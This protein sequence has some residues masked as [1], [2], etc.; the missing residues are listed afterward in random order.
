MPWSTMPVQVHDR[1]VLLRWATTPEGG[2]Y[3]KL[4]AKS[5]WDE[6]H[7]NPSVDRDKNSK[8]GAERLTH[9]YV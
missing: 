2:C 4:E 3:S 5:R 6:F 8:D 7:D 9:T 1:S